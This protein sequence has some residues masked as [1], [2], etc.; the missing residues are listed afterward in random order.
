MG[1]IEKFALINKDRSRIK[2]FEPFEDISN[3][4]PSIDAMMISYGCVYKISS[5][6]VIKGS[7]V[8]TIE[9]ARKEYK[10]L[11]EEGW[12]KTNIFKSYFYG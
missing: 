3:P 6:P 8:E 10:K 11:L 1:K 7:R 9:N 2:V 5:K 4:S 12:R